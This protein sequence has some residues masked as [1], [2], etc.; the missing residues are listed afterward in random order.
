MQY[1]RADP[2][3]NYQ[4]GDFDRRPGDDGDELSDQND[5]GLI[6]EIGTHT[7]DEFKDWE[8]VDVL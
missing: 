4:I 7:A 8:F 1:L 3:P 5:L 2:H 6:G